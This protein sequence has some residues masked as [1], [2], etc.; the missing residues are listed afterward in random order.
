MGDNCT[1]DTSGLVSWRH[2]EKI[3]VI[4]NNLDNSD[5]NR[6]YNNLKHTHALN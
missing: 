3:D 4:S 1:E 2:M 6:F 5:S